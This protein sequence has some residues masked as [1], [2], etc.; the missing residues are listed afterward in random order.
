MTQTTID[1]GKI[2]FNWKG[3]YD[4]AVTYY[5]DG[6][7]RNRSRSFNSAALDRV[8]KPGSQIDAGSTSPRSSMQWHSQFGHM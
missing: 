7:N 6:L 2:K 1:L 5:K 3:D 4:A 8:A